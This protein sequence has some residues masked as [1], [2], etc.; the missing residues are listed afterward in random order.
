MYLGPRTL[1]FPMGDIPYPPN[2][3]VVSPLSCNDIP[4]ESLASATGVQ[5]YH[6]TAQRVIVLFDY[7]GLMIGDPNQGKELL[8][9]ADI[10]IVNFTLS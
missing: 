2:P 1:P 7:N 8:G 3:R 10:A 6:V 9:S 4:Q 5:C